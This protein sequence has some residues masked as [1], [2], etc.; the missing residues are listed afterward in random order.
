MFVFTAM[1][2]WQSDV[3]LGCHPFGAICLI[4][5]GK[6]FTGTWQSLMKAGTPILG[7]LPV[8]VSP[9]TGLQ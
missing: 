4:F 6:S 5:C 7:D 2:T 8:S 9:V 3:N 1:F